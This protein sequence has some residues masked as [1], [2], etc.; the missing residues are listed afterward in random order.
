MT[1]RARAGRWL[2]AAGFLAACLPAL[3]P[4]REVDLSWHLSA[5]R[6]IVRHAR[7]P[8]TDFLTWTQQGRP[9]I[10]FEWIPQLVFYGLYLLGGLAALWLLKAAVFVAALFLLAALLRRRG[11]PD[12]WIGLALPAAALTL[13]PFASAR[14]EIA[15]FVFCLLQLHALEDRRLG[16]SRLGRR[17]SL[18]AHALAYAFWAN[19][20]P[21]FPL[22]LALCLCYGAWDWAAAGLL[23]TFANPYGPALYALFF[24]HGSRLAVLRDYE[25][26]WWGSPDLSD[27]FNRSYLALLVFSLAAALAS[28]RRPRRLP[29]PHLLVVAALAASS[30]ASRRFVPYFAVAAFPLASG[31]AGALEPPAGWSSLRPWLAAVAAAWLGVLGVHVLAKQGLFEGIDERPGR[32]LAGAASFLNRDK[33]VLSRL[34]MY[35]SWDAGSYLGF[36]LDPAYKVFMDGRYLSL[37]YFPIVKEASASPESWRRFMDDQRVGLVVSDLVRLSARDP[38]AP[39]GPPRP[40]DLFYLPPA[41]WALVY[42]DSRVAV[43]VRRAAVDRAWLARREYRYLHPG[44]LPFLAASVAGGKLALAKVLPEIRRYEREIGDPGQSAQ[45]ERWLGEVRR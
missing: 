35:C 24:A 9:W 25:R 10:D 26:T 11:V 14:P 31:A 41:E 32:G 34:S 29:I 5:G 15:S 21:A 13:S 45:L 1:R 4:I 39:L 33:D 36:E 42:W 37:R 3:T 17:A 22:G 23:G 6:F 38:A 27:M 7:V 30:L 8:T 40:L 43:W 12:A 16:V 19:S 18:A 28:L 2:L 44:D 20:H